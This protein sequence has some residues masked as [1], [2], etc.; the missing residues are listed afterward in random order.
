[1]S[2]VAIIGC[3]RIA[4]YAH[5]PALN[6]LDNVRIKYACD[7]IIEKAEKAKKDYPKV[8]NVILDY[9]DA[10]NDEEVDAVFV[11]VPNYEHK[12]I[13]IDALRAGKNVLCEKP[14][15]LNYQDAKEMQIEAQKAHKIL[16]IGVNNRYN[17]AVN[18]IKKYVE[19]GTLG[20]IYHVESHFFTTRSIPGLGGPFTTKK[21]SGGGVLIDWGVH[22]LDLVQYIVGHK[23]LKSVSASTNSVLA[24]N[25]K[26]YRYGNM[27][28]EDTA[29]IEHGINDVEE[30]FSCFARYDGYT[31][32]LTGG[33]ATNIPADE[34]YLDIYGS[35]A[36][37]RLFYNTQ[38]FK[39]FSGE[40]L[41][42]TE[43]NVPFENHYEIEDKMF[44]ESIETGK[45]NR[46][47]IDEV[48][49]IEKLI[50][51]IYQSAEEER[52]IRL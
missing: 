19:D 16:N 4:N 36:G 52:E 18:T 15:A 13:T 1:M 20:E 21:M 17:A 38:T 14:I 31:L 30:F 43:S 29:D 49:D 23:T 11:L 48:I 24:K 26:E 34:F 41:E 6:K 35:K 10:L 9:H 12:R 2:V 8:E 46:G 32:S 3:G 22:V 39:I 37:V 28:A 25:M 45:P 40:T 27:W 47:Y 33:W 44:I 5:L 51:T 7:I 42:V 50:D